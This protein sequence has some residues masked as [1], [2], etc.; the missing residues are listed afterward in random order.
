MT[1]E[2]L[3]CDLLNV[4]GFHTYVWG[5]NGQG[6]MGVVFFTDEEVYVERGL[7]SFT[8]FISSACRNS[9]GD[10]PSLTRG[11]DLFSN[12]YSAI[13]NE[14]NNAKFFRGLQANLLI[15]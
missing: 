5:H 14:E 10:T 1:L 7:M 11:A 3:F 12:S 2:V 4:W 13:G 8:S 9:S 15:T 6:I